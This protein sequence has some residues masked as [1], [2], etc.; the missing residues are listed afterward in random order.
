MRRLC[1]VAIAAL[2]L[3][4]PAL[5]APALAQDALT[6]GDA[7]A[8][9]TVFRKCSACHAVGEDAANRVG[10]QLNELF[11][12]RPGEIEGFKY[13]KGMTAHGAELDRVRGLASFWCPIPACTR[14][15]L[16]HALTCV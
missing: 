15:P 10:P 5:V 7:E 3:G 11:G 9:K 6:S 13:S 16:L 2:G 8:G 14:P 4:T 12:R 1:I